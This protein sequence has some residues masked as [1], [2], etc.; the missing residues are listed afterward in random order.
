MLVGKTRCN[1]FFIFENKEMKN[2]LK[3]RQKINAKKKTKFYKNFQIQSIPENAENEEKTE[4]TQNDENI[5]TLNNNNNTNNNKNNKDDK[6]NNNNNKTQTQQKSLLLSPL[7]GSSNMKSMT[8]PPP[9]SLKKRVSFDS[10]NIKS[11]DASPKPEH[12]TGSETNL[13]ESHSLD[14]GSVI[15]SGVVTRVSSILNSKFQI[16]RNNPHKYDT[17]FIKQKNSSLAIYDNLGMYPC[18]YFIY[19]LHVK[20]NKHKHK[21]VR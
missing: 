17:F 5:Q 19:A 21:Y 11:Q 6:E 15:R 9:T 4:V 3:K 8:P 16:V 2:I 10:N 7:F 1:Y 14:P 13:H 18:F 20:L 12:K